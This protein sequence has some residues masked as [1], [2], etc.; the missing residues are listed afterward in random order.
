ML[1]IADLEWVNEGPFAPAPTQLA[2]LRVDKKLRETERFGRTIRL[3]ELTKYVEGH[4]AFNGLLKSDFYTA[5][6]AERVFSDFAEWLNNDDIILWWYPQTMQCFNKLCNRYIHK[7]PQNRTVLLSE[8]VPCFLKG[9]SYADLGFYN[10]ADE[11]GISRRHLTEHYAPDDTVLILNILKAIGISQ[12]YILSENTQNSY[13]YTADSKY[14]HRAGCT[15]INA[16]PKNDRLF[17]PFITTAIKKHYSPCECCKEEYRAALLAHNTE[18]L[19]QTPYNYVYTPEGEAY[20]TANCRTMLNAKAFKGTHTY[21]KILKTGKRPCRVCNPPIIFDK[22]QYGFVTGTWKV[23]PRRRTN[24]T[25]TEAPLCVS[26]SEEERRALNRQRIA[27]NERKESL[28]RCKNAQELKDAYTLTQPSFAF[29]ASRGYRTFHIRSCPALNGLSMLS[30]FSTYDGARRAGFTPCRK[31]KPS[32]KHDLLLSVPIYS[33]DR[34][35][36][37]I[38]ELKEVCERKG[39]GYTLC[40]GVLSVSTSVGKWRVYTD[41]HP[42]RLEHINL[43]VSPNDEEYHQQPRVFLSIEDALRYIIKHDG[44]LCGM[45]T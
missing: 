38:E 22:R 27:A 11:V 37:N 45:R 39:Y 44:E 28:S 34:G 20:H 35:K 3:N 14:F 12:N 4:V 33:K 15:E 32:H 36:E 7:L 13:C 29:W 9:R 2:A 1:V 16:S 30:G 23:P 17:F 31:C 8:R 40:D 43:I 26:P 41:S 19:R 10:L 21:E 6:S 42:I 24:K 18:R 25:A 5:D